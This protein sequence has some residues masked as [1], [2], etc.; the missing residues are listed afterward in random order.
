MKEKWKRI[1]PGLYRLDI[2][3]DAHAIVERGA[4]TRRWWW[5]VWDGHNHHANWQ[6]RL[7]DSQ[8]EAEWKLP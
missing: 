8:R 7:A 6:W 4:E 1:R 2:N 5:S 3:E